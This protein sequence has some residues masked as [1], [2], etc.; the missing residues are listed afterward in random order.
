MSREMGPGIV[1]NPDGPGTA[2]PGSSASTIRVPAFL[3]SLPRWLL[4]LQC[5]FRGFLRSILQPRRLELQPTSMSSSIWPM[6][7][8]YPEVFRS[9]AYSRPGNHL[10]RLVCLQVIALD[11][12]CLNEPASAPECIQIGRRLNSRQ[13]SAVKMLEHLG[14]DGNT[15]EFID[16]GD[17]G[18]AAAKMEG[19]ENVLGA[20]SRA[21][22]S[23]SSSANAYQVSGLSKHVREVSAPL[24]CGKLV[25][26]CEISGNVTAKPLVS[27][28]LTLPDK[29][30]FDPLPFFDD[31][32]ADLYKYPISHGRCED[33]VGDPP[34]V[35]VRASKEEKIKLYKRMASAGMLKLVDASAV[36]LRHKSGLFSVHKDGSRDRM[37]MDSRP[38]NMA[39]RSQT[40]WVGAM[41]NASTLS[42]LCIADDFVLQMTGEDLKDYFYQ[43]KI[44][45]ERT[46]RNCLHDE[47]TEKEAVDIYGKAALECGP[48]YL[49]GLATLAM[50]DVSSC[51][52]A[53]ASHLGL[54][55]QRGVCSADEV[56]CLKTA[57][58][59]GLLQ[60]GIIID[61]LVILEQVLRRDHLLGGAGSSGRRIGAVQKAYAS[62]HLPNNPKKGFREELKAK[63]WGVE[64]DGDKGLL[65][66]SNARLWPTSVITLRVCSLGLATVGLME[67]LAGCWVALLGVRRRL[68]SL[69]GL[70]FEPLGMDDPKAV[71][72]LSREMISEMCL[73]VVLGPLAV[74]NLRAKHANFVVATDASCDTLAAVRADVT[75]LMAEE[76]A[77]HSLKKGNWSRLLSPMKA[78]SK[79][80]GMLDPREELHGE[81]DEVYAT[82]PLWEVV[83]R[84]LPYREMWRRVVGRMHHINVLELR[85]HLAEERRIATSLR[86]IRVPF[87]LDSQV[88]LGCLIKGRSSS[89]QLCCEMKRSLCY[90]LGGDI[91]GG[92]MYFPSEYNRADG[93][94]RSRP[95]DPPDIPLPVWW[96]SAS[97]GCYKEMDKWLEKIGAEESVLPFHSL[98]GF[99]SE[100]LKP[101]RVI[102]RLLPKKVKAELPVDIRPANPGTVPG[103]LCKMAVELLESLPENQFFFG[104]NFKGFCEPGGLDLFSGNYGVARQMCQLGCPWVLT[105]EW[106][107]SASEDLLQDGVRKKITEMMGLGC[108]YTMGAAPICSSFSVAITPP[109]RSKTYPRGLPGVRASMRLKLQQGNSHNDYVKDLVELAELHGVYYFI[110]NPDTSWWWRQKRW[111]R[112]R[113]SSSNEC[114]RVCFCRFG[115]AWKKPTRVA[116][117]TCLAGKKMWCTCRKAHLQLRGTHPTRRIPWTLVAQPYPRGFSRLLAMALCIGGGWCKQEKLNIERCC[118]AGSLRIGE[119]SNP[120]P[121]RRAHESR[122]SLEEVHLIRPETM[123][124][125]A[126]LLNEFLT[127][128]GES[129]SGDSSELFDMVPSFL[130]AALRTYADLMY[131]RGGAL[132]NLRHLLLAVQRWKPSCRPFLQEGWSM[133]A[134]WELQV[135]VVHRTPIPEALMKSMCSLAWFYGWRSWVGVTILAFY[136]AGRLGEILKCCREDLMLAADLLEPR[137]RPC[138]LKLR[139]FKSLHRQPARI[140]HMKVSDPLACRLLH[141]VFQKLPMDALLFS[142]SHYQYRKRWDIILEVLEVDAGLRLTPRGD[143]V[144]GA[145]VYHYRSG[146]AISD[147]L[148]L[149]RLRNQQT[150]ESY[151]QEVAALNT[152]G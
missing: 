24:K 26:R 82:H 55:L 63:F 2:S 90:A 85:A 17:M 128:C 123:R 34:P 35:Q 86:S 3:N 133:V 50:G 22:H 31:G 44:N 101:N 97:E 39:D 48:P 41:A 53:Q 92:Y 69:L 25:G 77:R 1:P 46:A 37:I 137:H 144:G 57:I 10:R 88:C 95:P 20:V 96:K 83:A 129:I 134:R 52:F 61:D 79:E 23:L 121:V 127:W 145:A 111:S 65:R 138:F 68:F 29:P 45:E 107:R 58:P 116:T 94:T 21:L 51:E 13:W 140:Q 99:K 9:G 87:A 118:R 110:E 125:E 93:P 56:L 78:W 105:Y 43:F 152:L 36:R 150:L 139:S 146:R 12:L 8:P 38:A 91:Y 89:K 11:W 147:V 18:R 113:N 62:V 151:L 148:W 47:L 73:L 19:F 72:R 75:P 70:I 64:I 132:S 149:L 27:S 112:W 130:G 115:C 106:N 33:E 71:I 124:M 49:V 54:C 80:H 67:A 131:Q 42:Q 142:A 40:L 15:P 59:R 100:E 114:F 14:T 143:S 117:N 30:M 4:Q 5:G 76:L 66:C 136:G 126:K 16:V 60:V 28:R 84:G 81:E 32:T 120:G 108:F 119:A 74:V 135:P 122:G 103:M 104:P 109:V 7:P 141:K 6:P 102:R 98:C